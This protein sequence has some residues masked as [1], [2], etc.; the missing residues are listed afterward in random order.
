MLNNLEMKP[1]RLTDDEISKIS[2]TGLQNA[3]RDLSSI[4]SRVTREFIE[5]VAEE[6][7]VDTEVAEWLISKE[8]DITYNIEEQDDGK[9]YL[10]LESRMK[11]APEILELVSNESDYDKQMKKRLL[12]QV[13]K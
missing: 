7:N 11:P 2:A 8:L 4:Y 5:Y 1:I 6:N 10:V 12:E 3:M 9:M 13:L